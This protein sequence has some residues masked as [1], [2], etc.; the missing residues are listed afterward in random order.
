MSR[1]NGPSR[2]RQ[3]GVLAVHDGVWGRRVL[4]LAKENGAWRV[5]DAR[6]LD[7]G[8][9]MSLQQLANE[10]GVTRVIRLAPGRETIGRTVL[11]PAAGTEEQQAQAAQLL[12]EADLPGSIPAYRRA[13]GVIGNAAEGDHSV[14]LTGWLSPSAADAL[15]SLPETWTTPIAALAA[16][17]EGTGHAAIYAE[18]REGAISVLVPGPAK[19]AARVLLE[20]QADD[21]AWRAAVAAALAE[22]WPM[23]GLSGTPSV[24]GGGRALMIGGG[25]SD[26]VKRRVHGMRDDAAW[27]DDYGLALGAA[28]LAAD[29]RPSRWAL[30]GMTAAAP[31]IERSRVATWVE[32]FRTPSRAGLL[33]AASVLVACGGPVVLAWARAEILGS[34][35]EDIKKNSG[36]REQIEADGDLYA[37]LETTRLPITKLMMDVSRAAPEGV[38]VQT[39]RLAPGQGLT[40]RGQAENG[41]QVSDFKARLSKTRVFG[42]VTVPR[43]ENKGAVVEFDLTAKITMPHQEV[44]DAE[45][46]ATNTLMK[47]LY[48]DGAPPPPPPAP[49]QPTR[50][51]GDSGAGG[52]RR[53]S[54]TTSGPPPAVS[55]ADIAKMDFAT[56][57]RGW[58][59]RRSYVQAN[60]DLDPALKQRLQDE[61]QKMRDRAAAVRGGG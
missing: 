54:V 3:G 5:A 15:T 57:S 46:F 56:A 11:A 8:G 42:D 49:E 12:A 32:Q 26:M 34:R 52:D 7:A 45:D 33:I 41:A 59:V 43:Q 47:R 27:L 48:P 37:Q 1:M 55:D 51:P 50:R 36:G 39:M 58:A 38:A 25:P 31:I 22:A 23:A 19:V 10:H 40:L 44:K 21:S 28:L 29:D 14:L 18:R 13:G 35:V 9:A 53:P 6:A 16:L 20:S 2:A 4:V 60:R 17:I 61:E 30:T 24:P